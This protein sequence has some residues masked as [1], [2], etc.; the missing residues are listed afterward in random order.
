MR[1]SR[2][3]RVGARYIVPF[4][5]CVGLGGTVTLP[6]IICVQMTCGQRNEALNSHEHTE[7]YIYDRNIYER[8]YSPVTPVSLAPACP[9]CRGHDILP[10]TKDPLSVNQRPNQVPLSDTGILFPLRRF[11]G[12]Y[13]IATHES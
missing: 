1:V 10:Y 11:P 3:L 6:I 7:R 4:Q 9:R 8:P 12:K 2:L 5:R 13:D